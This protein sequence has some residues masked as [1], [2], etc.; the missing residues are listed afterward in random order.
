MYP[1]VPWSI[2]GSGSQD[3]RRRALRERCMQTF[4]FRDQIRGDRLR[5]LAAWLKWCWPE[6]SFIQQLK[7]YD[8]LWCVIS[9]S[10]SSTGLQAVANIARIKASKRRGVISLLAGNLTWCLQAQLVC[11]SAQFWLVD[12]FQQR[13]YTAAPPLTTA[14]TNPFKKPVC[15]GAG[16]SITNTVFVMGA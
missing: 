1:D 10:S 6:N 13:I 14:H 4:G 3:C 15:E 16:R 9:R 2:C 7:L 11:S 12:M 8:S 5:S